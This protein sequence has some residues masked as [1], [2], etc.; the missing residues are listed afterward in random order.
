VTEQI[1]VRADLAPCPECHEVLV[2][3]GGQT[4]SP[5]T[6]WTKDNGLK[7]MTPHA[8]DCSLRGKALP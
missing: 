1:E 5:V 4:A 7:Q 2:L 6:F 8:E 3:V